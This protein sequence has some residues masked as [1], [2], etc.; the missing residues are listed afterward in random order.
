MTLMVRY[1]IA[2]LC[3]ALI[4][5]AGCSSYKAELENAQTEIVK[6]KASKL[7]LT[8]IPRGVGKLEILVPN[9]FKE[10]AQGKPVTVK[11]NIMNS[12]TL[13]LRR[14]T[15]KLDLPLEWEGEVVPAEMEMINGGEKTLFRAELTPPPDVAVGDY[16]VK[17]QAEG[18]TGVEIVE[19]VDKNLTVRVAA[20]SSITGTVILVSVLIVLVI[21]I[22]VASI[23][24]SRR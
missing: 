22:A 2:I 4:F 8:L 3:V 7:E 21:G 6:L 15:P 13:V 17:M 19:A 12:G 10:V 24:I 20:E 1:A 18:H 23:K 9:L 11:F 14:V 5:G 16:T